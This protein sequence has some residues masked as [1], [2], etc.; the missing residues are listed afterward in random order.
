MGESEFLSYIS[1]VQIFLILRSPQLHGSSQNKIS[2]S[3]NLG[4]P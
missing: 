1:K 3:F 2:S 4:D